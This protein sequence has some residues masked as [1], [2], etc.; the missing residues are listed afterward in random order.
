M[1]SSVSSQKT[2]FSSDSTTQDLPPRI[3]VVED[4]PML[5]ESL[6]QALKLEGYRCLEAEDGQDALKRLASNSV[7]AIISDNQMPRMRGLELIKQV[8]LRYQEN[9][10]PSILMSGDRDPLLPQMA[11]DLNCSAFLTK[12]FSFPKLCLTLR[13][14]FQTQGS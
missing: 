6:C 5:R 11:A 3:L 2:A 12:P 13:S 8:R 9:S 1:G 4:D 10:P 7:D 14:I